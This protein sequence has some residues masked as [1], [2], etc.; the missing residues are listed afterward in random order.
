LHFELRRRL[1]EV[2]DGRDLTPSQTSVLS[3]L[4][5]DG[6]SSASVLAVAE[7]VRPQSMATTLAA[8]QERALIQRQPDPEDGR[9]QVVTLTVIGRERVE[10]NRQAREVWLVRALRDE[11]TED[12]RQSVIGAM[13][14]L[15]R[16]AH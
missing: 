2:A 10:E 1:R 3:R 13:A 7:H 16:I 8:L 12:E 15:E 6:P 14:V 5:K 4:G 11:C 9:R